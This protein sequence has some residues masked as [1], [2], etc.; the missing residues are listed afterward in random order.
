M[1][2][3]RSFSGEDTARR[4]WGGAWSVPRSSKREATGRIVADKR[5]EHTD[6]EPVQLCYP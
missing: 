6:P 4:E 5:K 2:F 3:D 1:Q